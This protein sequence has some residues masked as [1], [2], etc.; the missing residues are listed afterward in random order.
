[1]NRYGAPEEV[2]AAAVC[3][4]LPESSYITGVTLAVDGGFLSG[5]VIKED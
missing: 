3:L 2:A 5:G 4:A 1:M